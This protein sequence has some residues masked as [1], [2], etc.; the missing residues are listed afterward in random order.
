MG[1]RFSGLRFSYFRLS[2]AL[3]VAA[4]LAAAAFVTWNYAQQ[5]RSTADRWFGGYVDTTA[6][7]SYAFESLGTSAYRNVVLSFIV[8]DD[9][10]CEPS[11]GGYYSPEE[12]ATSLD[13]DRRVARVVEGGQE[14]VL[15]FGGQRSEA[16]ASA[17]D[18]ESDLAHAYEQ[19]IDRYAAAVIDLDIE[20]D[21]LSD[22]ESRLRRVEA[23][24]QLQNKFSARGD[25]LGVW[26]TL[27]ADRNG[28]TADG[29]T[30]VREYLEAGVTLS[31]V[32]LMVM[33]FGVPSAT[34]TQSSLAIESLNAGHA[35]LRNLYWLQA[36]FYSN[37]Q[38]WRRL[39]ATP[40]IGQNDHADEVFTLED[41]RRLHSFADETG[42]GRLSFWSLNRDEACDAN[43]PNLS[44]VATFCSGVAQESG[45]F[46][47][48]LS[49]G[50]V[51][52]ASAAAKST[53][54][55]DPE[56][57]SIVEDN[58]ETSPYQIWS[59][60]AAYPAGTKVVWH[61]NVYVAQWWS[62]DDQPDMPAGDAGAAWRLIGPV[63]P[64][65]RPVVEPKLPEGFYAVWDPALVYHRGDRVLHEGVAYEAKWW[66][67][68]DSPDAGS[69]D[70]GSSPWDPLDSQ[71]IE[72][73]LGEAQ[74]PASQ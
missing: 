16:L 69:A 43:Y 52:G 21:A 63:M 53:V 60:T 45:Q 64:E 11:W 14:I 54:E 72:S 67:Q 26:V 71:E 44:V 19:V 3:I 29:V 27:P 48:I 2:I 59:P 10:R 35:Q 50:L 30:A 61:G 17:C 15:S 34:E 46:A 62:R 49:D 58:P 41:A 70:P 42:L 1:E 40:M 28:L 38:V 25:S 9:G 18:T 13:L 51:G 74:E 23:V 6:T 55:D 20:G 68:G 4:A 36:D 7:P 56:N 73:L 22:T 65:D 32:N 8:S 57:T 66:T 24:K 31:G 5:N 37:E 33:N 39:G 12:A 47:Q